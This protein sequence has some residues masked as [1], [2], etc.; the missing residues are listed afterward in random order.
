MSVK[1]YPITR[2]FKKEMFTV[3]PIHKLYIEQSG[4]PKGIPLVHLHGGPGSASKPRYRKF[5]NPKKYRIILF[6]QRGAGKSTPLGETRENTTWDLVEDIEK[7]RKHLGITKWV[8]SGGS[9]GSTLA[10][11]YAEKYPKAVKALIVRGIFTGRKWEREWLTKAGASYFFPEEWDLYL[12]FIPESERGN[13]T[14]AYAKRILSGDKKA[15]EVS[16]RWEH[17][18]SSLLPAKDKKE[19]KKK[20]FN[21]EDFAP[22]KIFYH[23]ELAKQ[24]LTEGQLLKNVSKLKGIPGIIIQGRYD[25]ICPPI[26]AWE[27]HK[28]WPGSI[29]EIAEGAGHLSSEREITKK[30]IE[31]S[32]RLA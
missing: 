15:A 19:T 14:K 27:L 12:K 25:M 8:V 1:L 31:A 17:I 16:A 2:V 20:A 9:W 4:N 29:L 3:S 6:D 22:V 24:F 5:Y 18:L 11:T 28:K 23:Y 13:L 30:L 7:I 10:L 21:E 26:T 32:D